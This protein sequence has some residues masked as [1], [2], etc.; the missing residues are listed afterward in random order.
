MVLTVKGQAAAIVQDGE[1]HQRLLDV[2]VSADAEEG[3]RQE[4]DGVAHGRTCRQVRYLTRFAAN[5]TYLVEPAARAVRDLGTLRVEK[6]AAESHTAARWYNGL[7]RCIC[8]HSVSPSLPV[9]L[10]ALSRDAS[11]RIG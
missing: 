2:A 11:T 3:I 9:P 6:N 8:A 7:E 5:M 1:A 10:S 4:L